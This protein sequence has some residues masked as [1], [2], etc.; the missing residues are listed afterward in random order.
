MEITS[1][2]TIKRNP[3]LLQIPSARGGNAQLKLKSQKTTLQSHL[4]TM[5][6]YI[7]VSKPNELI[8]KS[9]LRVANEEFNTS[10]ILLFLQIDFTNKLNHQAGRLAG[11]SCFN[12]K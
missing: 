3:K 8:S 7:M 5:N 11:N 2:Q 6:H 12:G 9:G 10:G 4:T 1:N